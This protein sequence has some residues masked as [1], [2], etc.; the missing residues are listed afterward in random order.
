MQYCHCGIKRI[1]NLLRI[2]VLRVGVAHKQRLVNDLRDYRTISVV[3]RP[4]GQTITPSVEHAVS[5]KHAHHILPMILLKP[6]YNIPAARWIAWSDCLTSRC[7][8]FV[9]S[10]RAPRTTA[11]LLKALEW[12]TQFLSQHLTCWAMDRPQVL[13]KRLSLF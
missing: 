5:A 2:Q 4:S 10:N 9:S 13:A 7:I 3:H 6:A 1:W 12:E 8:G 11:T